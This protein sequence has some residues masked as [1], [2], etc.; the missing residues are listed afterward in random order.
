MESERIVEMVDEG[1]VT[2][3]GLEM[4]AWR[5]TSVHM[6]RVRRALR[7]QR[8]L[9]LDLAGAALALELLEQIEALRARLHA[10]G[11]S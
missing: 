6:R 1:V 7:L 4:H 3:E 10:L 9:E 8:E 2:P 5:F 11:A